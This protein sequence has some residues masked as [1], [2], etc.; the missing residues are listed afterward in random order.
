MNEDKEQMVE[1]IEKLISEKN[2]PLLKESVKGHPADI[3]TIIADLDPVKRSFIFRLLPKSEAV[4]VF[5][6]LDVDGQTE[7]LERFHDEGTISLVNS[8]SPDDRARLFDEL[9]A[10]VITY[11]L[12]RM[13]PDEWKST[14]EL[15]GYQENTAGRIMTPEYIALRT[16][17]TVEEAINK[18]KKTGKDKETIYYLYPVSATR[19]LLGVV[20][21]KK[22]VLA[23]KD[24]RIEDIMNT[25]VIRVTTET[26]QEEVAHIIQDYDL[27][28]VPVVDREERLVGIVTVDDIVD[29]IEEEATEDML[30][31]GGVETAE[32]G[33]FKSTMRSNLKKRIIWLVLM[34]AI[35]GFTGV[36]IMGHKKLL[37]SVIVLSAFIPILIG[38]GGNAGSQSAT[39]VIRGLAIGE[40]ALKDALRILGRE[41]GI[42]VG[43]GI[44]LGFVATGFSY[45]LQGDWMVA[46]VVGLSF[47]VVII[48]ATALG[49]FLPL[50]VKRI[51][52]D[53]ALIATPL[54]TTTIDVTALLLY[55]WIASI[56]LGLAP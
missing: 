19:R 10:N 37:E 23:Q 49:T 16:D 5:E 24:T 39:V 42:G 50:I 35:N 30:R 26:D 34:L 53:P 3:A 41:S 4:E 13:T 51:G 7:L 45:W 29:I 55:F 47:L 22:V 11:L 18:I 48:I 12:R 43:L 25:E 38:S 15:L 31:M 2:Y 27:L 14:S 6:H 46:S 9:P 32:K 52:L 44:L 8:M 56:I 28:A 20:S 17:L 21:L 33:Y 54:I 36:I 40:I 1:Y